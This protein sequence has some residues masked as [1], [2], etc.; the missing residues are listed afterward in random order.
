MPR[1]ALLATLALTACVNPALSAD[2]HLRGPWQLTVLN[3][4]SFP[5]PATLWFD[6]SG[7]AAGQAPC[8]S[9]TA[10]NGATLPGLALTNIN[11]TEMACDALADEVRFFDT[12][13]GMK[14]ATLQDPDR[15]LLQGSD[16]RTMMFERLIVVHDN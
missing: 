11:S 4:A 10:T 12:L 8:N 9:F 5:A 1:L 13:A 7:N 14:T 6:D 2:P 3:G 15:L 16:G